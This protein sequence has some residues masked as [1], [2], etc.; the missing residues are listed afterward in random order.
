M[1]L[2]SYQN[3]NNTLFIKLR[4][5]K[6]VTIEEAESLKYLGIVIVRKLGPLLY[7]F[8]HLKSFMGMHHLHA[9]Y[10]FPVQT[11]LIYGIID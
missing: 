5:N 9:L 3:T 2:S 8:K 11:H 6:L 4:N 10:Y 7:K 1:P